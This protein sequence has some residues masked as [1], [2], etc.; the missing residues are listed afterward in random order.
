MIPVLLKHYC[1][2]ILFKFVDFMCDTILIV[3]RWDFLGGITN[4]LK[5]GLE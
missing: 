1:I 4:N 5:L 3:S 2:I